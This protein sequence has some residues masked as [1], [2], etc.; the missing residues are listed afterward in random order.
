MIPLT[1]AVGVAVEAMKGV[2]DA[3][4]G[5]DPK[6]G[7]VPVIAAQRGGAVEP[8]VGAKHHSASRDSAVTAASKAEQRRKLPVIHC[9]LNNML[10]A[11]H[12]AVAATAPRLGCAV[13]NQARVALNQ[14]AAWPAAIVA[15]GKIIEFLD[16]ASS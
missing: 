10:K 1:P 7:A 9:R 8:A 15:A 2:Q 14:R 16:S 5:I 6:D 4:I 12:C 11:E 3:V 13:V